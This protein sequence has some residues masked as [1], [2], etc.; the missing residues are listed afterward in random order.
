MCLS[1]LLSAGS[2]PPCIS[3]PD[4]SAR[5]PTRHATVARPPVISGS[6]PFSLSGSGLSRGV[7][8]A[9][10]CIRNEQMADVRSGSKEIS[11]S[12]Q[13]IG[14]CSFG[15]PLAPITCSKRLIRVELHSRLFYRSSCASQYLF[16]IISV[17]CLCRTRARL[18]TRF[19]GWR[20]S[21]N[22][23]TADGSA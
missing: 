9:W 5:C 22:H 18:R 19:P 3:P 1:V 17:R 11:P 12:E 14:E 4:G 6:P 8:S 20:S 16:T 15:Q 10:S 13:V 21:G 7:G 23:C 2:S